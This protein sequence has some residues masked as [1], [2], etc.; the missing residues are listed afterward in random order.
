MSML[1]MERNTL[2]ISDVHGAKEAMRRIREIERQF[3]SESIISCGDLTPDPY[4]SIFF[5]IEGCRGNCDRFYEYGSLP[6]PPLIYRKEIY[7]KRV[8]VTHGHFPLEEISSVDIIFS[9]HTHIPSKKKKDNIIYFNPGSV[10]LPRSSSGP[11]FGLFTPSFLAILSLIDL[12][13]I[14]KCNFSSS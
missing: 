7:G 10:A 1:G 3:S 9:G 2:I 6:F 12:T 5:S 14:N 8:L 13:V 4:D 11:T